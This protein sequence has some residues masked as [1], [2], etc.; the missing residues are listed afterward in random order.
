MSAR[1]DRSDSGKAEDNPA[2]SPMLPIP[3]G[4]RL[5]RALLAFAIIVLSIA[6]IGFVVVPPVVKSKLEETLSGALNRKTTVEHVAFNPFTLTAT[7]DGIVIRNRGADT[8]LLS[9]AQIIA[10]ISSASLWHRAPVV[11]GLVVRAPRVELVRNADGS[12]NI[13]DL[14]DAYLAMPAGPPTAFSLNN[15]EVID[16]ALDFDDRAVKR[17]HKVEALHVGIPFL[18]SLP[19]DAEIKVAPALAARVDGAGFDLTGET[20]PFAAS[21]QAT[22]NF[23]LD[24]LPLPQILDYLPMPLKVRVASGDLTTKLKL[25]F[26]GGNAASRA[27]V[28]SGD[29]ALARLAVQ[30]PDGAPLFAVSELR[31]ALGNLDVFRHALDVTRVTVTRP[32]FDVRRRSDGEFEW[33][34]LAGGATMGAPAAAASLPWQA[35]VREVDVQGATAR[36]EDQSTAPQFRATLGDFRLRATDISN[37]AGDKGHVELSLTTDLGATIT[38][39]AA[40]TLAPVTALGK[41]STVGLNLKR[42]FPYYESAINLQ[43]ADGVL[44][45]VTSFA[46]VARDKGPPAIALSGGGAEVRNLR[47]LFPGERDP[48]W[49]VP[50]LTAAGIGVDVDARTVTIDEATSRQAVLRI[51][52]D[53]DGNFNFARIMRTTGSTGRNAGQIP[54]P[55]ASAAQIG[56]AATTAS[57]DATW[58]LLVRKSVLER[59]TLDFQDRMPATPVALRFTDLDVRMDNFSNGRGKR[60]ALDL[61]TRV[62]SSGSVAVKGPMSTNPVAGNFRIDAQAI[63]LPPLQPYLDA[64]ANLTITSGAITTKGNLALDP[65]EPGSLRASY[66]GDVTVT[67]FASLDKPSASDLVKWKTLALTG[68]EAASMPVKLGIGGIALDDFYARLIVYPDGSLNLTQLLTSGGATAKPAAEAT[69]TNAAAGVTPVSAP[70]ATA[71]ASADG[72]GLP[73]TIGQVTLTKGDVQFSDFFVK[74]NY[75]AHLTDLSGRI[76]AMSKERAGELEITAA[77]EHTAP[78]DIRGRI[79]PFASAIDLDLTAKAREIELPPLSPYAGKYA[80]YAIEKGKLS[81]DVH[82]KIENRKLAA[83]NKLV[84]DQLKFGEKIESPSATKLP[85]LLAVA[86]LRDRNGVID[87]NLPVSGSLDDPKFSVGGLIIQ[88][89]VNLLTKAVTAPFA[90]LGAVFGGGEQLAYV[91]FAPGHASITP[92][93]EVKLKALAKALADRPGLKI[94]VT[95]RADAATDADDLRRAEL[96]RVVKAQ[97]RKALAAE[98]GALPPLETIAVEPAEYPRYLEAAYSEATFA[99]PRNA[100]GFAKSL[101]PPEM[102]ALIL[103]NAKADDEALRTLAY[104]R[105]QVVKDWLTQSGGVPADRVFLVAPKPG[106]AAPQDGGKTCRVDFA[107]R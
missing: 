50:K 71:N 99:K 1:A 4:R 59:T 64:V 27:L 104:D 103:Q 106:A 22:L 79:N 3:R 57:A 85:V 100:I 32:E 73:V 81:F 11:D 88:V 40:V 19:H 37:V 89:I 70:P 33:V 74:P 92:A 67:D 51:N 5:R 56:P 24:A 84:L 93:A 102:E 21:Q 18:S 55:G 20:T 39:D 65:T 34:V 53:G 87:I 61:R 105:A 26:V 44:D 48:L 29:I 23:D 41:L 86:L 83:E 43:V 8:T 38:A 35:R 47:L 62:G 42:L 25:S 28:V 107:L 77:V 76:S 12:Y 82:Y 72:G 46:V 2:S 58:Q 75:S 80:G 63:A 54:A 13:Q 90:L 52:R 101:P 31:M 16:G 98:Q 66:A 94:D 69:P 15:I 9:V 49:T 60:G 96:A 30:R 17:V 68:I 45:F 6:V 97:K 91:E 7:L 36:L 95:G 78:V 10:N 14:I